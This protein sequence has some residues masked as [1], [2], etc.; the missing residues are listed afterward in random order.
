MHIFVG[1][2]PLF[3]Y[4]WLQWKR[5][6][7]LLTT[8]F[9]HLSTENHPLLI[10]SAFTL[11]ECKIISIFC[12]KSLFPFLHVPH[13]L[14]EM[15]IKSYF[16]LFSE[17]A[18]IFLRT[19]YGYLHNKNLCFGPDIISEGISSTLKVNVPCLISPNSH[20][21]VTVVNSKALTMLLLFVH[22]SHSHLIV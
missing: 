4:Y 2:P 10:Y 14:M 12:Q 19:C 21:D 15:V 11:K 3:R 17:V 6:C 22:R 18:R 16:L 9:T 1:T 20:V 8:Q 5:I 7:S 13:P